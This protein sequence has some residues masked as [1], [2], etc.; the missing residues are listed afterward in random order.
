VRKSI[1]G[2]LL[3]RWIEGLLTYLKDRLE[4]RAKSAALPIKAAPPIFFAQKSGLS[5]APKPHE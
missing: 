5:S 4:F 3:A 2:F 1:S